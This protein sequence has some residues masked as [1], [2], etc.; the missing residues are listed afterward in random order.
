LAGRRFAEKSS[1]MK[2]GFPWIS[3]DSLVRIETYQWVMRD[4]SRKIFP[5]S[6]SGVQSSGSDARG[7]G[8][9]EGQGWSSGKFNLVSDFLQTIVVRAIP[10]GRFSPKPTHSQASE[11]QF[12]CLVLVRIGLSR[13][14]ARS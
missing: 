2:V 8:D 11:A 13:T 12:E 1:F 5:G 9:R 14:S 10:V 7:R 6:L 4:K 3:L